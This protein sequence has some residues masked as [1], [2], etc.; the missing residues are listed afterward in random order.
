[1]KI[2]HANQ[3]FNVKFVECIHDGYF[4]LE[5]HEH[6]GCSR[7]EHLLTIKFWDAQ[8]QFELELE[9]GR[10]PLEVLEKLISEA[11]K[12]LTSSQ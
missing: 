8:G 3:T 11:K 9:K 5:L 6:V 1:M 7:S 10:V 12:H 2:Q 4:A